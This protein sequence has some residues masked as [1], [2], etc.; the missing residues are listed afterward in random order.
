LATALGRVGGAYILSLIFGV[1][2]S[3]FAFAFRFRYVFSLFPFHPPPPPRA[4]LAS[5]PFLEGIPVFVFPAAFK[6]PGAYTRISFLGTPLFFS[7]AFS[8]THAFRA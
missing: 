3:F 8:T 1:F 6:R 7:S 4:V 5:P 2:F